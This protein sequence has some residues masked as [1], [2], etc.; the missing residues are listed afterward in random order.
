MNIDR[1]HPSAPASSRPT[2][3]DGRAT[4][5][6]PPTF[7]LRRWS[8]QQPTAVLDLAAEALRSEL[9]A[10]DGAGSRDPKDLPQLAA[11]IC[12]ASH[13]CAAARAA[14]PPRGTPPDLWPPPEWQAGGALTA[15][16]CAAV[17]RVREKLRDR[18]PERVYT[19]HAAMH[20][21]VLAEAPLDEPVR[22]R[23]GACGAGR[24]ARLRWSVGAVR[25][26]RISMRVQAHSPRLALLTVTLCSG[27]RG[28][29]PAHA[30]KPAGPLRQGGRRGALALLITAL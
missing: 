10:P 2:P 8:A 1:G 19:P 29:H 23:L 21:D 3:L 18:D 15:A 25:Q 16:C 20:F 11:I 28:R 30:H 17:E 4:T 27:V 14:P 7:W 24:G 6:I 26:P 9:Y 13:I 22:G 12:A 5:P